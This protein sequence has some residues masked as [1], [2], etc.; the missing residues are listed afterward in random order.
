MTCLDT[1]VLPLYFVL[2]SL[3]FT[4]VWTLLCCFRTQVK[5]GQ[6]SIFWLIK[7]V[8]N[9]NFI[10]KFIYKIISKFQFQHHLNNFM[11]LQYTYQKWPKLNFL[12]NK[13]GPKL[14]FYLQIH[15]QNHNK[16]S[17]SAPFEHF[18]VALAHRLE[19]PK[20]IFWLIKVDSN[21]HA[22]KSMHDFLANLKQFE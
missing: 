13:G 16:I 9:E 19:K 20:V 17:I 12:S 22:I 11:L 7:V 3:S 4:F 15:I 6:N 5:N 2:S 8:L 1:F 21:Y 14:K 10:Y 18:Y